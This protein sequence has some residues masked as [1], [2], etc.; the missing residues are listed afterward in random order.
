MGDFTKCNSSVERPLSGAGEGAEPAGAE[1]GKARDSVAA[2]TIISGVEFRSMATAFADG[3]F[4]RIFRSPCAYSNSSKLCSVMK[5]SSCSICWIS[6]FAKRD[7]AD[8]L[9]GFFG[10]MLALDLSKIPRKTGEYFRPICAHSHVILDANAPNARDVHPRLNPTQ[11][12]CHYH[13]LP[14]PPPPATPTPPHPQSTP[15][16]L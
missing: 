2:A 10:F 15:R 5:R 7:S 1:P 9:E 12:P 16:P 8:V 13:L 11:A 4:S 3:F 6:V 14:P